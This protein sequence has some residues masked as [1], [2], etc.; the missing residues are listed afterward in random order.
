[1]EL[2][3]VPVHKVHLHRRPNLN[4]YTLDVDHRRICPGYKAKQ[5]DASTETAHIVNPS[6]ADTCEE[7]TKDPDNSLTQSAWWAV[8]RPY[9]VIEGK[10]AQ[11]VM[12]V[13]TRSLAMAQIIITTISELTTT[14]RY[15][16]ARE[17]GLGRHL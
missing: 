14:R 2:D 13:A 16:D 4:G 12:A 5:W 8:P 7:D 1:M 10:D 6:G 9:K 15:P 11:L 3:R 17:L